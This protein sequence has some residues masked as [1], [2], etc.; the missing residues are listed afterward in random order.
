MALV[1]NRVANRLP[2][3][4]AVATRR[5]HRVHRDSIVPLRS[6]AREGLWGWP[7]A[8]EAR[9]RTSSELAVREPRDGS[10]RV[11][12][13]EQ[14]IP[15]AQALVRR[16]IPVSVSL[17]GQLLKDRREKARVSAKA[18]GAA[19]SAVL[20]LLNDE[21]GEDMGGSCLVSQ[22]MTRRACIAGGEECAAGVVSM[23]LAAG[24]RAWLML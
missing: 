23:T 15:Q 5:C 13:R 18:S 21:R 2:T 17:V 10:L 9:H 12:T 3:C 8:P 11:E 20:A 16:Y 22:P 4:A 14:G 7:G 24:V 6:I 19:A 1:G